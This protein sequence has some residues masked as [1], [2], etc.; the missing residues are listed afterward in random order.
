M[1]LPIQRGLRRLKEIKHLNQKVDSAVTKITQIVKVAS[2]DIDTKFNGFMNTTTEMLEQQVIYQI[3][4]TYFIPM[5]FSFWSKSTSKFMGRTLKGFSSV[6][7]LL[8]QT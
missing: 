7:Q 6:A 8:F 3:N 4:H 1:L 2:E 5:G